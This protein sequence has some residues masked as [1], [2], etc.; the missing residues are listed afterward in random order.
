[1][2]SLS[3]DHAEWVYDVAPKT[4]EAVER[5]RWFGFAIGLLSTFNNGATIIF[6][7]LT[8]QHIFHS[9]IMFISE[10]FTVLVS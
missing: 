7:A 8:G 1:M 4:H 6:A 3:Y 10:Y 9:L 5:L 2:D